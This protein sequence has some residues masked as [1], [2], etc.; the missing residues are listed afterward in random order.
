[1]ASSNLIKIA[2]IA[3]AVYFVF[4]N[5]SKTP[6]VT[7]PNAT[8]VT[9]NTTSQQIPYAYVILSILAGITLTALFVYWTQFRSAKPAKK[10]KAR[11]NKLMKLWVWWSSKFGVKHEVKR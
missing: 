11:K 5:G 3:I 6:P 4:L 8:I 2:L 1:M 9:E 7:G 10:Q